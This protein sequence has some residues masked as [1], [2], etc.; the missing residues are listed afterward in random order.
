MAFG[1]NGLKHKVSRAWK[2][3]QSRETFV[4]NERIF[5]PTPNE[6]N[7]KVKKSLC[8]RKEKPQK[9]HLF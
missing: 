9:K 4:L 1:T 6:Q 3:K 2:E 8:A 5:S 7:E